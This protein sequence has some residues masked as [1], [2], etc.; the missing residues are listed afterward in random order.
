MDTPGPQFHED[1]VDM[2][3][4]EYHEDMADAIQLAPQ[5]HSAERIG[6]VR[7]SAR[8]SPNGPEVFE[9]ESGYGSSLHP[10]PRRRRRRPPRTSGVGV[11]GRKSARLSPEVF[12][13][14]RGSGSSAESLPDVDDLRP[15]NDKQTP[16]LH[17]TI[18]SERAEDE[19][20][21]EIY[22]IA[23]DESRPRYRSSLAA[24]S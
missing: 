11:K 2:P 24:A 10:L 8:L 12:E 18:R 21:P 5:V 17:E 20:L 19:T 1:I 3:G 16:E 6:P 14:S 22:E 4:P 15:E 23:E 7:K 9:F 13:I